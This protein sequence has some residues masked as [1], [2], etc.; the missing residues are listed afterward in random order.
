MPRR[1]PKTEALLSATGVEL[2][3]EVSFRFALDPSPEVE[4]QLWSYAGASRFA[5]N[6]A[7]A[8]VKYGLTA[9][10]WER[11]LGAEPWSEVPWSK[12]SLINAFNAW[13]T[14]RARAPD[15]TCGLPW[16]QEVCQ[17]VFECAMVDL[18]QALANWSASRSGKQP[19][20]RVGFPR[21]KAKK[22]ATPSFRLRTRARP[23]QTQ[24]IRPTDHNHVQLPGLGVVKHHGSNR[25]LR[26]ML[27]AGRLHV[28]SA[29]VR[30]QHG[31]WWISL[32]GLAAP[33]HSACTSRKARHARHAG[34]DVGVRLLA[35]IADDQGEAIKVVEGVNALEGALRALR[36]ANRRLARTKPGSSGRRRAVARLRSLHAR[37]ANLRREAIHNL[38][39][40]AATQLTDLTIEDL[41]V[42]GMLSNRRLARRLADAGLAEIQRQLTYKARWYGLTLHQ[43]DRW[44][45]SSKTCSACGHLQRDL[46]L[47]DTIWR[48]PACG[49]VHDRD[50]NAAV[51]LARWP[52][53]PLPPA[54]AVA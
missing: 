18:G 5:W 39:R 2:T 22:R 33:F 28:Y 6:T 32:A 38:T 14:G 19:G 15:G 3:R 45:P 40:W 47:G 24:E 37:V 20:R 30:Y 53:R 16:R 49:T 51:N 43:A 26:R 44:Y 8:W 29:T 27:V 34:M 10:E 13:K 4:A 48:C 54:R 50:H 31:R 42:V 46:A 11:E 41:N 23:G 17:D 21:F 1:Q 36:R 25:Q 52:Q 12:F 35:I 9:R 7:L